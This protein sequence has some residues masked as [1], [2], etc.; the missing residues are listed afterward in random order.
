ML[1][2]TQVFEG[3]FVPSQEKE[4]VHL[5]FEM[6]RGATR[7]DVEYSYSHQIDSDPLLSGGN[8]IDLGV[9][10]ARG[11]DFLTA[12]FRGWS[13]SE[14]PSFFI[15]ETEATPGYLAGALTPGVWHVVLG[16]YKIANEGCH[17][18]VAVTITTDVNSTSS[19]TT[20]R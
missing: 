4:Y 19:L 5:P 9:F 17:Y 20:P 11:I 15:T 10:D 16:L 12:G 13:G 8:T 14:R 2:Q 7:L 3:D 6:P 18:R 1:Q